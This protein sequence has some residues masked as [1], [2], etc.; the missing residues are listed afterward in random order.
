MS[1][2]TTNTSTLLADPILIPFLAPSFSVVN[3]VNSTLP[4]LLPPSTTLPTQ[5]KHDTKAQ[6]QQQL[7]QPSHLNSNHNALPLSQIHPKITALLSTLDIQTHRLITH[8]Q[9]LT[10]EILRVAPRLTYEVEVL[11]G[12]VVGLGEDLEKVGCK[13]AKFSPL[14][15]KESSDS[16]SD[17]GDGLNNTKPEALRRLE[18]LST[19][20]ARLEE[21]IAIFGEAMNWPLP[22]PTSESITHNT[23]SN[24]GVNSP[25]YY[26]LS[27]VPSPPPFIKEMNKTNNA[28]K[29]ST[30]T[31]NPTAEISYLLA[32]NLVPQARSRIEE[33]RLLAGVFKGTIE[34]DTRLELVE[35][36]DR[37]VRE[38]EKL[39]DFRDKGFSAKEERMV[40]PQRARKEEA[41]R[42]ETSGDIGGGRIDS[43]DEHNTVASGFGVGREGY[44]GLINQLQRMRGM[45]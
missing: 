25:S 43:K 45:G 37:R 20:R 24:L 30:K 44:Y 5:P 15:P 18:T 34:E 21:V 42:E 29:A 27:P 39:R 19:I 11:R 28:A 31:I 14:A 35:E 38:V 36:L 13:V 7:S 6:L 10:D 3:Y 33:L 26:N 40:M 12:G 16:T 9:N 2:T 23:N 32:A 41:F 8:L 22:V 17:G 4:P 1:S